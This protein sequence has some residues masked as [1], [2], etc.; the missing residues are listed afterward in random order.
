MF[1]TS[2]TSFRRDFTSFF[3][4]PTETVK[5]SG[6]IFLSMNTQKG[7]LSLLASG[8][9]LALFGLFA[10]LLSHYIGNLTQVG[11]RMI[12]ATIIV[13]P[14]VIKKKISLK[15]RYDN[16]PLFIVFILSFPIYIIFFTISVN[17]T[18][19]ANAFFY[20]FLSS[21][22]TAYII[23][24]ISFKERIDNQKIIV[25]TLLIIGLL[26]FIYPYNL[27]QSIIGIS[28]GLLG[29]F[30]WGLSNATRKFYVDKINNW[31]VIVYQMFFGAVISFST[32][33]LLGEFVKNNWQILPL[34]LLVVYAIGMV[35]I[36]LLLYIGF[37]NF[38]L[39]L[40]SIVLASQ[41]VFVL[42]LGVILLKEFPSITE[43]LGATAISLAI[44]FSKIGFP[45]NLKRSR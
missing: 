42:I 19:L 27:G 2:S 29:G 32:A 6:I 33:F 41:L 14:Y 28:S 40:G 34:T 10:R 1:L 35:C 5:N 45:L 26:L 8:F 9:I 23:G 15:A 21:M 31:L 39:N 12:I 17:T 36:Q 37:K 18:K 44:V 11:M 4:P 43:L 38:N 13:I 24:F 22:L 16:L 20:L 30:F 7:F 25:A 3:I